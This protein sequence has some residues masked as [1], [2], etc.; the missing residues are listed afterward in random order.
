M[1]LSKWKDLVDRKQVICT[2]FLD[3]KRAF[4][5]VNRDILM[6][7]LNAKINNLKGIANMVEKLLA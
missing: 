4:E 3:F 7:K 6:T 1:I 5:T 2:V